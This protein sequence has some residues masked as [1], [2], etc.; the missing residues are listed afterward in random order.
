MLAV[1]PLGLLAV[2][3]ACMTS[4]EWWISGPVIAVVLS[5]EVHRYKI[6]NGTVRHRFFG[7]LCAALG[8]P[9]L[10]VLPVRRRN[11]D[12]AS[13]LR[14]CT[15]SQAYCDAL[16]AMDSGDA[17]AAGY[18]W[19]HIAGRWRRYRRSRHTFVSWTKMLA[20]MA[21]AGYGI[22][23]AYLS[24]AQVGLI[25]FDGARPWGVFVGWRELGFTTELNG[26]RLPAL[27]V[28][29]TCFVTIS[30]TLIWAATHEGYLR[31]SVKMV[32]IIPILLSIAAIAE[33]ALI[34]VIVILNLLIWAG[35]IAVLGYVVFHGGSSE[36]RRRKPQPQFVR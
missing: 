21:C 19:Q 5:I 29:S 14:L 10:N 35:I 16:E 17:H 13:H 22:I 26:Y 7:L 2:A 28:A 12:T 33:I 30:L 27:L 6:A 3:F 18:A 23:T 9:A 11:F 15:R 31:G 25:N 20:A 1:G 32:L 8:P 4:V 36:P 24:A 34:L